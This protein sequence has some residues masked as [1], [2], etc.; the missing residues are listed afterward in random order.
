MSLCTVHVGRG[1]SRPGGGCYRGGQA[2]GL[3]GD[4]RVESG[5]GKRA[6]GR[7]DGWME[8]K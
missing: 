6:G 5:M 2:E 8:V 1:R 4:N 3:N 7:K